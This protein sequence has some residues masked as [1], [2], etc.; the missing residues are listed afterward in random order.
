MATHYIFESQSGGALAPDADH[1][2]ARGMRDCDD[3]LGRLCASKHDVETR[4]AALRSKANG[5]GRTRARSLDTINNAITQDGR[6]AEANAFASAQVAESLVNVQTRFR[7]DA[8]VLLRLY[9]TLVFLTS[10]AAARKHLLDCGLLESMIRESKDVVRTHPVVGELCFAA[11]SRVFELE[12]EA[13]FAKLVKA[14]LLDV[15]ADYMRF[16]AP[17]AEIASSILF[18]AVEVVRRSAPL[19]A[20]LESLGFFNV[21]PAVMASH[22]TDQAVGHAGSMLLLLYIDA[23][24]SRQEALRRIDAAACAKAVYAALV[25]CG[26]PG[27]ADNRL[28]ANALLVLAALTHDDKAVASQLAALGASSVLAAYVGTPAH[29]LAIAVLSNLAPTHLRSSSTQE[30]V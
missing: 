1:A 27:A 15:L 12:S 6:I 29:S 4:H 3:A 21:L 20:R 25:A 16:G 26:K 14:G 28:A 22:K 2:Y 24:P 7:G 30:D 8:A 5:P 17:D 23:Q 13:E 19:L 9:K 11:S 10:S 18:A